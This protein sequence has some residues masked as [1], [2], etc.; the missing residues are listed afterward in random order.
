MVCHE[1]GQTGRRQVIGVASPPA[2]GLDL[3]NCT[4]V[5]G[6]TMTIDNCVEYV[7][8]KRERKVRMIM[9][10][11]CTTLAFLHQIDENAHAASSRLQAGGQLIQRALDRRSPNRRRRTM[12]GTGTGGGRRL[13][14]E[15]FCSPLRYF[16]NQICTR[17]YM[18]IDGT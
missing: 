8:L 10:L 2:R 5:V 7:W 12:V 15:L 18:P 17:R 4:C 6:R 1:T 3:P 16:M 9:S 14:R 11:S 13:G